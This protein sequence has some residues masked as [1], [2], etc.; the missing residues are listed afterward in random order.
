MQLSEMDDF[1]SDTNIKAMFDNELFL[2]LKTIA[3]CMNCGIAVGSNNTTTPFVFWNAKA[4]EILGQGPT[5]KP[6]EEWIDIYGIRDANGEPLSPDDIPLKK[7]MNGL[8]TFDQVIIMHNYLLKRDLYITC[9]AMPI[10][11]NDI[12]IG[13]VV[14]FMDATHLH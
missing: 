2:L 6:P 13:G 9:N 8:K 1:L 11:K 10:I 5:N 3:A 12:V 7:A 14:V 4:T